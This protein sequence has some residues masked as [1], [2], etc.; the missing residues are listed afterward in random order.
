ML[1]IL[2]FLAL[3]AAGL[4]WVSKTLWPEMIKPVETAVKVEPYYPTKPAPAAEILTTAEPDRKMEKLEIILDEKNRTIHLLETEIKIFQVQT[5]S[6]EKI[7]TVMDEEIQRL[8]EQNRIFRSEL[9]LP[10]VSQTKNN[11][12]T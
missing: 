10:T 5:R 1:L 6:F 8:R 4:V 7:K 9:G 3:I 12:I 11:S 2:F